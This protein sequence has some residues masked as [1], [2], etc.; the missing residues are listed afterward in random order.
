MKVKGI[1]AGIC[2]SAG[3]LASIVAIT[4][5]SIK[6]IVD[7]YG[8]K[9][10]ISTLCDEIEVLDRQLEYYNSIDEYTMINGEG[11]KVDPA[12]VLD[13]HPLIEQMKALHDDY[14]F[15]DLITYM[16][17][18]GYNVEEQ[19]IHTS[20]EWFFRME[21]EQ[22]A[23]ILSHM[24]VEFEPLTYRLANGYRYTA[25][26][27]DYGDHVEYT[28]IK[29]EATEVEEK[30]VYVFDCVQTESETPFGLK[31]ITHKNKD[32]LFPKLNI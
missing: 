9:K 4:G 5:I 13:Y 7:T 26:M 16:D 31:P 24:F 30:T 32:M 27:I 8:N 11:S 18:S 21:Y 19:D 23:E 29:A 1:Y 12:T 6:D 28:N 20:T 22:Q 3:L 2:S 14:Y 15:V 17:F 25:D 10:K